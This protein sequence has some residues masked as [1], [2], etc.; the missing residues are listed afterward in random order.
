MSGP[1]PG[2]WIDPETQE[3][4]HEPRKLLA[5]RADALLMGYAP[6][7][8]EELRE[9]VVIADLACHGLRVGGFPE[10]SDKAAA[11]GTRF[12]AAIA[13]ATAAA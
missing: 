10:A 2:P 8:L 12:R 7:M 1:T 13:K 11:A 4:L 5:N 3:W 6:D 9:A